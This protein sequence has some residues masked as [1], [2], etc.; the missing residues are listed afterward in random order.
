MFGDIGHGLILM[1]FGLILEFFPTLFKNKV[2]QMLIK[3][4]WSI[5]LMGFFS[6]YCG[7]IYN[8]YFSLSLNLFGSCYELGPVEAQLDQGC[9]YPFGLDPVWSIAENQLQFT[10]SLKMKISVI[11]AVVH[12]TLGLILKA[13]NQIQAKKYFFVLIETLPQL[14]FFLLFFGYMDFLIIYKWTHEWNAATA[15]SIITTMIN[16]PLQLGRTEDCC[17]GQ[18]MWGNYQDTSQNTIQ[19]F[20]LVVMLICVPMILCLKPL[21]LYCRQQKKALEEEHIDL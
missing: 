14:T 2:V 1:G 13:M 12:M 8:E 17:G 21:Y 4:K 20:I 16:I 19:I 5:I 6:T 7:F 18:P 15:P 3:H 11:I 9:V 10:N